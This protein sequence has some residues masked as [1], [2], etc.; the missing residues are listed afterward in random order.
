MRLL[1]MLICFFILS[2]SLACTP[3]ESTEEVPGTTTV[4][5]GPLGSPYTDQYGIEFAWI[6]PGSFTMGDLTED[7]YRATPVHDV[8]ITKG[9]YLG[10]FEVTQE[11]ADFV[12]TNG[13]VLEYNYTDDNPSSH[14]G[15][16]YPIDNMENPNFKNS[17]NYYNTTHLYTY[18]LPTEAEWEYAARAG[19]DTLYY[20]GDD[21]ESSEDYTWNNLNAYNSTHAVGQKLPNPWGLY[22]MLGNVGEFV[23]DKYSINDYDDGYDEV[24]RVF[25]D[26]ATD[27]LYNLGG[28]ANIIRGGSYNG[29]P[30]LVDC[31]YRQRFNY[32]PSVGLRLVIDVY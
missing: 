32:Q 8:I 3:P 4:Y 22:D 2:F 25:G 21:P 28:G 13:Y 23:A 7:T 30:H 1:L 26:P 31:S 5:Q 19:T 10:K 9:F 17:C 27:P 18:R 29:V 20:W 16:D 24:I 12:Y 6:E 11:Q 14:V 15:P